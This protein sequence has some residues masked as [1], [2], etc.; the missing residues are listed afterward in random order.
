[1]KHQQRGFAWQTGYAAFAVSV[2][3]L[4]RVRKYIRNQE[5]HHRKITFEREYI[6]LLEKHGVEYDLKYVFD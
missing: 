4:P 6:M 1:M 2:S 5:A 3:N